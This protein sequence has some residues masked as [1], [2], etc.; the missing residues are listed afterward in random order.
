MIFFPA[1]FERWNKTLCFAGEGETGEKTRNVTT[2]F[3]AVGF[4]TQE[5]AKTAGGGSCVYERVCV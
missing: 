4:Y 3:W 5:A 1:T 2:G